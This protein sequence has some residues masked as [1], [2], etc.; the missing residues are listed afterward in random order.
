M[1]GKVRKPPEPKQGAP[2]YIVT[3]SD[4]IT[5]LLTFF[6]LLLSLADDQKEGLFS[7]GQNS[8]KRAVA[9]FGLAGLM[10]S[11]N[12]GEQF[13]HPK[14]KYKIEKGEDA[15][16]DRS[17]DSATEVYRRILEN[18]EKMMKISPSQITCSAKTIGV[19]DIKFE[20]GKWD[21]DGKDKQ[22]LNEYIGGVKESYANEL[23]TLY[24]VGLAGMEEGQKQQWIVSARRSQVVADYIRGLL[25]KQ[26]KWSIYSWGT[27]SGG[28][29]ASQ[30]GLL[31]KEAH[32]M[33][34]VLTDE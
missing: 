27:G 26:E 6:V 13:S 7:K 18:I 14:I 9:D 2:A 16:E 11:K 28:K 17:I 15:E 31:S 5:L 23:P 24:V 30:T 29:W 10:F 22:F 4:M 32:I 3:F 34:A 8:F 19:T 33:I 20:K 21:L 12:E 25:S 1:S